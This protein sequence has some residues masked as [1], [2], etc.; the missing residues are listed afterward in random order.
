MVVPL[1]L[2]FEGGSGDYVYVDTDQREVVQTIDLARPPV[3]TT[4][5]PYNWNILIGTVTKDID[6]PAEEAPADAAQGAEV[7]A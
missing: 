7:G 5:D 4:I 2:K 1:Y 6:A 3:D